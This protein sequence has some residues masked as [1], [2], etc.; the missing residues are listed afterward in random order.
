MTTVGVVA[1]G[2]IAADLSTVASAHGWSVEVKPLP[3]L[4]HNHPERITEAVDDAL[5]EL[6]LRHDRL[7]VGYADCGTYGAL[8]ELC[9][10]RGVSRLGGN[11]CY[12]VF[13]G[14]ERMRAM[15]EDQAGTY[16][17]TDFLALSFRRTILAELGLDE[18]PQ[19]RDDYFRHYTRIVW[20]AQR[21]TP[22][23]ESAANDAAAALDLP[24]EVVDVGL[25]G[26][27]SELAR[28]VDAVT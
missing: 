27:E 17:L 12:D 23:L 25:L 3:P 21:R 5:D 2:A 15:F 18:H 16:V 11:H 8:D 22:E 14:A 4:L 28:L 24:L 9:T 7:A 10:R 6:A 26:L 1:C 20:L 19:L 13:A